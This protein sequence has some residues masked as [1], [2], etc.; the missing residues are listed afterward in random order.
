MISEWLEKN[1]K[2]KSKENSYSEE[3]KYNKD[4]INEMKKIG[5]EQSEK[6]NEVERI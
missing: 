6:I 3:K 1:R 5:Q 2:D 4:F